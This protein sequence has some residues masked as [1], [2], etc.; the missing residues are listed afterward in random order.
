MVGF[1]AVARVTSWSTPAPTEKLCNFVL[2]AAWSMCHFL[3]DMW[4]HVAPE[5]TKVVL[6]NMFVSSS[7]ARNSEPLGSSWSTS[8][9]PVVWDASEPTRPLASMQKIPCA[10]ASLDLYLRSVQRKFVP[11]GCFLMGHERQKSR[12]CHVWAAKQQ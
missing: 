10:S 1:S 8:C 2:S 5:L 4:Y 9:W 3:P 11:K 6:A 7:I 12:V